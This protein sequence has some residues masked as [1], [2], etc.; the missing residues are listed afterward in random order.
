MT[1]DIGLIHKEDDSSF[2]VSF[3]DPPGHITAGETVDEALSRA[4]E[5]VTL[6]A[7]HWQEDTGEA[8]PAPRSFQQIM[9][10]LA[11]DDLPSDATIIA[12]ST[13]HNPFA[14]IAAE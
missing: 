13:S 9:A 14:R 8:M 5:L 11:D 7:R 4:H 6:L 12:V 1:V 10:D 2:G 3:P